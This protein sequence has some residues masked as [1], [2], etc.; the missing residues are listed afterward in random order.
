MAQASSYLHGITRPLYQSRAQTPIPLSTSSNRELSMSS[1]RLGGLAL[2]CSKSIRG[3]LRAGECAC[4]CLVSN[5]HRRGL[6][7]P[8][9][10]N[11]RRHRNIP[12]RTSQGD[13]VEEQ[14]RRES[15]QPIAAVRL[16]RSD[17]RN[18]FR[19]VREISILSTAPAHI[20][21]TVFLPSCRAA[22]ECRSPARNRLISSSRNASFLSN[23]RRWTTQN[24]HFNA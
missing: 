11:R 19:K 4:S 24:G 12:A 7:V 2:S 1:I 15:S 23:E 14:T 9:V 6:T 22:F 20:S 8:D 13:H 3:L 17:R 5:F 21:S 18:E 16:L 10:T